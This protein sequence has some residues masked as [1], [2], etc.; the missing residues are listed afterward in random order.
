MKKNAKIVRLALILLIVVNPIYFF[1]GSGNNT[2]LT[3]NTNYF[4]N[5]LQYSN[6]TFTERQ[7]LYLNGTHENNGFH[8]QVARSY[9]G[10]PINEDTIRSTMEDVINLKDTSDFDVN[11]YLRILYYDNVSSNLSSELRADL[12]NVILNFKYWFTEPNDDSMIF[13][14]ENHMILFHTAELLAGQLYPNETFSNSGMTGIEHVNHAIPLINRWI[15]WRAQFGF[16]EWHSN[17]YFTYDLIALMNLVEFSEDEPISTKAMM[18]VDLLAFDFAN[19]F[20]H[21]IYATTHGRTAD[22]RQVGHSVD[23]PPSR[24]SPS[25]AAWVL[26][27]ISKHNE[28][29]GSNGG[30]ISIA[31]SEKYVPPPILEDIAEIA[32]TSNE[33][34]ER[35]SLNLMDG[36]TYG[37]GYTSMDDLMF[38]WPMSATAAAPIVDSSLRLMEEYDLSAKLIFNDAMFVDLLSFGAKIHGTTISGSCEILDMVT[39]GVCL[40]SVSTYTYRTPYYQLSGAQDY[41]KGMDGL[42]EH[43]WQ[44]SLDETAIVYA[45]SPGGVSPQEF[46][47]GWKPRATMNEN[48]GIFQYDRYS[49]SLLGEMVFL[50]LE[51]K[52]YTHAYFPQWAFD[53]VEQHG[54]WTFGEKGDSYVALYSNK[55]PH[56]ESDI[57][58][59]SF[60]KKNAYIVELASIEDY[61]SFDEFIE[62]ILYADLKV[63]H[64]PIGFD[65][66]YDSPSQGIITVAWDGPMISGGK[67]VDLGPFPRF[68]NDFCYQE[69]GTKVTLIE[70]ESQSLELDFDSATRT[71]S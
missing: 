42:Q 33:H 44:A 46:T 9:L 1:F 37:I 60:G 16:S 7:D 69:F 24:E 20:F 68:D 27:G 41:H 65:I 71:Y 23:S 13:W 4:K 15:G 66:M 30:A 28:N 59:R 58:L 25:E 38:W 35:S 34:K 50:Y 40:E 19:N 52:P 54:K 31:V 64:L 14:T 17:V 48:V 56:W 49:T 10:L 12:K 8:A 26:L 21:S 61:S 22:S 5:L 29:D 53:S 70:F 3:E 62:T 55:R 32:A 11:T 18:L 2:P 63:K 57:E 43:I 47:G 36:P 51:Y 67:N 45:N 39:R 6:L